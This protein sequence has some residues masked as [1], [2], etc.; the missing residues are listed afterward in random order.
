M[1]GGQDQDRAETPSSVSHLCC[2]LPHRTISSSREL[3]VPDTTLP[4]K[5]HA[6]L[7]PWGVCRDLTHREQVE[8]CSQ[9]GFVVLQDKTDC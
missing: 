5:P 8:G 1:S 7:R 3:G 2:S 6:V 9:T 4:G